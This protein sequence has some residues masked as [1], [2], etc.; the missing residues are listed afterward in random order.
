LVGILVAVSY[1]I[2]PIVEDAKARTRQGWREVLGRNKHQIDITDFLW[3]WT[4]GIDGR[5]ALVI[6]SR[7]DLLTA[8]ERA[9]S[10]DVLDPVNW[11]PPRVIE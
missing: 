10:V 4:V 2:L 7:R 11:P 6:D 1:L 8:L 3:E 9:A 5:T